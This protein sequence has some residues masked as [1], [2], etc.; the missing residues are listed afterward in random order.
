MQ[1]FLFFSK[2][3]THWRLL[4]WDDKSLPGDLS[5][6]FRLWESIRLQSL[7]NQN[8]WCSRQKALS[9]WDVRNLYDADVEKQKNNSHLKQNSVRWHKISSHEW[10]RHRLKCMNSSLKEFSTLGL[11]NKMTAF[12]L[13]Y[14]S[15]DMWFILI[16][17]VISYPPIL[18]HSFQFLLLFYLQKIKNKWGPETE[19]LISQCL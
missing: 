19:L 3:Y 10:N 7:W 4:T 2:F 14:W 1:K 9:D 15:E 16:L 12:I 18:L 17:F 8:T 11:Q 13:S 6:L 5:Q